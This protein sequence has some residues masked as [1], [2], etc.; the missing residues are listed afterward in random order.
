MYPCCN[1]TNEVAY[2]LDTELSK[3]QWKRPVEMT[4][5]FLLYSLSHPQAREKKREISKQRDP[6]FICLESCTKHP[7]P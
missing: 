1:S 4:G 3:C 5:D 6:T 7:Q 2:R